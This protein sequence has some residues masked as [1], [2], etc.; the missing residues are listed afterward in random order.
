MS[1]IKLTYKNI[2]ESCS[3]ASCSPTASTAYPIYRLYDRDID[4]IFAFSSASTSMTVT[5]NQGAS[6]DIWV[7]ATR[8]IIP[9]GHNLNGLGCCLY[10]STDN[11]AFTSATSWTQA[12]ANTIDKS[13]TSQTYRY[14]KFEIFAA[15]SHTGQMP[16]LFL[17]PDYTFQRNPAYGSMIGKKTNVLRDETQS[18]KTRLVKMGDVRKKGTYDLIAVQTSQKEDLQSLVAHTEGA[19]P[20]WLTDEEG[21][22]TYVEIL[23][24]LEFVYK[25]YN[26]WSSVID[27]QEVI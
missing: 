12:N 23:N 5:A 20:L 18:G 25:G 21:I 11:A 15:T 1:S 13:F 27:F 26:I 2:Y 16:E 14:F 22:L 10:Y 8:L 7:S 6:S 24:D 3:S 19:K 9:T 4:K 17:G